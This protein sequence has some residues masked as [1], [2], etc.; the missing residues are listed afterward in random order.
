MKREGYYIFISSSKGKEPKRFFISEFK[1]KILKIFIFFIIFITPFFLY[2]IYFFYS[3]FYDY[4]VLKKR[5]KEYEEKIEKIEIIEK[6]MEKMINYAKQINYMLNPKVI[7]KEISKDIDLKKMDNKNENEFIPPLKGFITRG[8]SKE[9]P[10][11]DIY[12]PLG[13]PVFASSDGIVVEKSF[14]PIFGLYIK[15]KHNGDIYTLYGHL[16]RVFVNKGDFVRKG[17]I[18]GEVGL[19]GKTSG[20]HL[21]FEILRNDEPF[22]PFFIF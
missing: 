3:N 6:K 21:H 10:G 18:I 8:F 11:I 5:I 9:H 12:A 15:I 7:S 17:D 2:S 22:Y 16:N 19:T 14:S 1:L 13:T 20:P 4:L